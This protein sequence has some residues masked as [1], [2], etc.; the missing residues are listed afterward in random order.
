MAW[1]YLTDGVVT[2]DGSAGCLGTGVTLTGNAVS[3]EGATLAEVWVTCP[4]DAGVLTL[5]VEMSLDGATWFDA[6]PAALADVA[7]LQHVIRIPTPTAASLRVSVTANTLTVAAAVMVAISQV[8]PAVPDLSTLAT[9]ASVEALTAAVEDI[10]APEAPDLTGLA[11]S[12]EV[13][14]VGE[15]VAAIP[16]PDLTGLATS[17]DVD[18]VAAAVAAIPAGTGDHAVTITVTDGSKVYPG[19]K[20]TLTNSAETATELVQYTDEDGQAVFYRDQGAALLAIAASNGQQG[21]GEK[22]FVVDGPTAVTVTV[23]AAAL[24]VEPVAPGMC[25][26]E[27]WMRSAEGGGVVGAGAG[28]IDVTEVIERA[29]GAEI[30]WSPAGVPAK[31]DANGYV[32]MDVPQGFVLRVAM[33]VPGAR[34]VTQRVAV[35]VAESYNIG[36]LATFQAIGT[37]VAG[38][39]TPATSAQPAAPGMCRLECWMRYAEGGAA[40]GAGAGSIDVT[41]VIERAAGA[42]IIWSP[43][44]TPALTD[45]TGYAYV[46]VPQGFELRIALTAPG[47]RLSDR[48]AVPA[49]ESLN[50]GTLA[51]FQSIAG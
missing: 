7:G 18:A 22:A 24:P 45:A 14:A 30:V 3:I 17:S 50:I 42:T 28:S 37:T 13:A 21:G 39:A 31:T 25:R 41:E 12:T 44:G 46:D 5:Q 6:T 34:E 29:A 49:A 2:L 26:L 32:Y 43:A 19:V 9:Q 15:A 35:P 4:D 11:K 40:V 36:A 38:T 47:I 16:A 1:E 48:V 27:C 10:P 8:Q 33:T 51:A 20:V 23:V